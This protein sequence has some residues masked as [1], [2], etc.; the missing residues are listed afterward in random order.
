[1]KTWILT[2]LLF[3]SAFCL[4]AQDAIPADGSEMTN[5][6]DMVEII[7]S[8]GVFTNSIGMILVP[9]SGYWA[10]RFEVS[11]TEYQAVMKGNPSK[12][13]RTNNPVDN[14]SW[15][16]AMDFCQKLTA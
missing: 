4:R 11:Q 12:F 15:D 14:V 8:P 6:I 10:C 13:V 9:V 3:F 1:M 16:N 5:A 7:K 2:G